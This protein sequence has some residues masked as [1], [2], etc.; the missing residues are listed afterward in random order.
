MPPHHPFAPLTGDYCWGHWGLRA[1]LTH[2]SPA[3]S[4]P[5]PTPAPTAPPSPTCLRDEPQQCDRPGG[6]VP[7]RCGS[8]SHWAPR[9]WLNLTP[10][11]ITI[12]TLTPGSAWGRERTKSGREAHSGP[13]GDR[14][15]RDR[16]GDPNTAQ[17]KTRPDFKWY[18]HPSL[19]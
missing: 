12:I 3:G 17:S 11:L 8:A 6:H 16:L 5:T 4:V 14:G 1:A 18:S 9:L 13:V 15:T 10:L 2:S 7:S 19:R